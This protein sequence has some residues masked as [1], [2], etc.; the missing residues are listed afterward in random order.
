[1]L[2][3]VDKQTEPAAPMVTMPRWPVRPRIDMQHGITQMNSIT[4][5]GAD[6][7]MNQVLGMQLIWDDENPPGQWR[8]EVVFGDGVKYF[9][10]TMENVAAFNAWVANARTYA[11]KSARVMKGPK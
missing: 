11:P 7:D 6:Y 5:D 9:D 1:M 4:L 3:A 10:M 8:I 2:R